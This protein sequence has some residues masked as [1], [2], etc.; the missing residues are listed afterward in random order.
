[1]IFQYNNHWYDD[2][3]GGLEVCGVEIEAATIGEADALYNEL[4]PPLIPMPSNMHKKQQ[5]IKEV[6][7]QAWI[8]CRLILSWTFEPG[9]SKFT[10]TD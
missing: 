6:A 9:N 4:M 5:T 1:M 8:G 2:A 10:Q 7:K 3:S